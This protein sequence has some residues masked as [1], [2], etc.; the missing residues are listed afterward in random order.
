M[1]TGGSF[2]VGKAAEVKN[3][4]NYTSIPHHVFV[5]WFLVKHR[6]F[7]FYLYHTCVTELHVVDAVML[8]NLN[9]CSNIDSK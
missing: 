1:R 5:A 6:G 8:S 4:W 3:V 9:T 7:T 2:S